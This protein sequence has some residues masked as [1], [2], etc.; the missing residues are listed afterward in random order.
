MKNGTKPEATPILSKPHNKLN[1]Y[2][3][4]TFYG[5]LI[6][7]DRYNEKWHKTGDST[8]TVLY[9]TTNQ[10][11]ILVAHAMVHRLP[12]IAQIHWSG[13]ASLHG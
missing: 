11:I 12:S 13:Q 7:I 3:S 2:I 10:I 5:A 1:N 9:P 8:D 4:N 6:S